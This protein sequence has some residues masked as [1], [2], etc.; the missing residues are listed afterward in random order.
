MSYTPNRGD[1]VWIAFDFP[2][3]GH[4]QAGHRPA[5]ILSSKKFNQR[6]HLVFC[7]PVTSTVRNH[8]LEV[9][10]PAELRTTGVILCHHF[11][12]IDWRARNAQYIEQVS[13]DV[14]ADV[15]SRVYS[16]LIS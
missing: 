7:V 10:L 13:D 4:E 1:L 2:P 15:I 8:P 5:L 12:S 9:P 14:L 3:T 16:I 6:T 11:K